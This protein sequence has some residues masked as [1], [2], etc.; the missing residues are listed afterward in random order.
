MLFLPQQLLNPRR[1]STS[2]EPNMFRLVHLHVRAFNIIHL[3]HSQRKRS[4]AVRIDHSRMLV[5]L[6]RGLEVQDI[7]A[8]DGRNKDLDQIKLLELIGIA[9]FQSAEPSSIESLSP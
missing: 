5:V 8:V 9:F 3:N 7:T 6:N 4:P 1:D 2:Y